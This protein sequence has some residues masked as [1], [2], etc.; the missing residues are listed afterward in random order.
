MATTKTIAIINADSEKSEAALQQLNSKQY[1]LLFFSKE[2]T[3]TATG[4]TESIHCPIEASW[5]ADLV[6][7]AINSNDIQPIAKAIQPVVTQKPVIYITET[8]NG[9]AELSELLPHSSV[10]PVKANQIESFIQSHY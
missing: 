9:I 1:R 5:E 10:Y 3:E 2:K 4:N 6:I 7:L 8:N